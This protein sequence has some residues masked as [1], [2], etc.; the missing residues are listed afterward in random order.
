MS[1]YECFLI[2]SL[3]IGY[4]VLPYCLTLH[5]YYYFLYPSPIS[6]YFPPLPWRR[7]PTPSEWWPMGSAPFMYTT[8]F[9]PI[10]FMLYSISFFISQST[11]I[12][13]HPPTDHTCHSHT[14]CETEYRYKYWCNK[15]KTIP[16]VPSPP[17]YPTP[18]PSLVHI[19]P[20][21]LL[22]GPCHGAALDRKLQS[23]TW[24]IK[25]NI[26]TAILYI[27]YYCYT[28]NI[29]LILSIVE[30]LNL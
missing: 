20:L 27:M 30:M 13:S 17:P 15:K 2:L 8:L 10:I 22:G 25:F 1:V 14:D 11:S 12:T 29:N 18:L 16:P 4:T 3:K 7:R 28:I 5:S 6:H 19:L 21:P 9:T 26:T 24:N 23:F